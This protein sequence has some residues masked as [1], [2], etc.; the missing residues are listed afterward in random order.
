MLALSPLRAGGP[1]PCGDQNAE[2]VIMRVR[3][4]CDNVRLPGSLGSRPPI[5]RVGNR[6]SRRSTEYERGGQGQDRTVDLPLSG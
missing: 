2:L 5:A 1:R 6:H 3:S 4:A